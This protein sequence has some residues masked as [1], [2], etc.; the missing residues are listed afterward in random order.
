MEKNNINFTQ[1][2]FEIN[3]D[4]LTEYII[5]TF[6]NN[7]E[8]CVIEGLKRKGFEFKNRFELVSFIKTNCRCVDIVHLKQ[9]TFFVNDIPFLLYCYKSDTDFTLTDTERIYASFTSFFYL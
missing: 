4:S 9:K 2:D 1:K 3:L 5:T 6:N 7:F 8:K